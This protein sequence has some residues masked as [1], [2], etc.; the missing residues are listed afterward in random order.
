MDIEEHIDYWLKS[1]EH[2]MEVAETLFV[3]GKLDWCLYIAH[4]VLEKTIKAIY[5]KNNGNKIPPKTHN[6]VRLAEF[7]KLK[8]NENQKLFLDEVNDFNIMTRYPDYKLSFYKKCTKE[9]GEKYFK[10]IKEFYKWLISR[11][12]Y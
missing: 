10:K 9:F 3:N 12:E 5:V 2:D 6:L 11:I 8:L 7:A 1:G 4:L